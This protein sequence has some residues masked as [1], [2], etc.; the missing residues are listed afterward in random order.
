MPF[1]R[2]QQDLTQHQ[3]QQQKQQ[4]H[5]QQKN[6]HQVIQQLRQLQHRQQHPREQQQQQQ[7]QQQQEP[8][9]LR[10]VTQ[11]VIKADIGQRQSNS[12]SQPKAPDPSPDADARRPTSETRTPDNRQLWFLRYFSTV[13]EFTSGVFFFLAIARC[14]F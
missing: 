13:V 14:P 2:R 9:L 6:Q 3:Q 8:Q 10:K 4:Q 1:F 11:S 12:W 7:Q 5:H